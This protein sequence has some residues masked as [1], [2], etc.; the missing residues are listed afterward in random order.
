MID[1]FLDNQLPHDEKSNLLELMNQN[2]EVQEI[3][4]NE[5]HFRDFIKNN[6]KRPNVS[7]SF[8]QKLCDKFK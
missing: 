7:E 3:L 5:I 8:R 1:L 6:V 2:P 4:D